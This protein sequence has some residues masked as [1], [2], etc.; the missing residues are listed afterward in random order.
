VE[1]VELEMMKVVL[2]S[3][4]REKVIIIILK[5]EMTQLFLDT[6]F[7]LQMTQLLWD[8]GSIYVESER[9][10]ER[11]REREREQTQSHF[12]NGSSYNTGVVHV[13]CT[14]SL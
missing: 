8:G 1:Y 14:I 12:Y 10:R 9:A 5:S 13:P 3:Y 4:K 11:E 2:I 7:L 6:F